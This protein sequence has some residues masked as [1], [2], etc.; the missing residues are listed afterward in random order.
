MLVG[1]ATRSIVLGALGRPE[2]ETDC[3]TRRYLTQ[4]ESQLDRFEPAD[5]GSTSFTQTMFSIVAQ[6]GPAVRVAIPRL[7]ELRKRHPSPFVR[8]WAREAL[9][10]I[11]APP[12]AASALT[13]SRSS[14]VQ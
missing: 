9:D 11:T 5:W 8:L 6:L 3:Q 2:I 4:L 13:P 14:Q 1:L 7:T 12:R 10:K